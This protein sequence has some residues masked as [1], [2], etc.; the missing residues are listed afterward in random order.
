MAQKTMQ[1]TKNISD[2]VPML[3]RKSGKGELR[4]DNMI[5]SHSP[6]QSRQRKQSL[7]SCSRLINTINTGRSEGMQLYNDHHEDRYELLIA[8]SRRRQ[9]EDEKLDITYILQQQEAYAQEMWYKETY[10]Q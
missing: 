3:L 8:E 9:Q 5:K 1:K 2:N 6:I 10:E 4:I 7:N